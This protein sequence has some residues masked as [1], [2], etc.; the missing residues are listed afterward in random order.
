MGTNS[1]MIKRFK[2]EN[3]NGRV[4]CDL[5]F[6]EDIN[7]VTGKNGSGKTTLLKLLWF[8]ISGNNERILHEM[9]FTSAEVE[10]SDYDLS[11][12][13]EKRKS[14][15]LMRWEIK[16]PDKPTQ[17]GIGH[18]E[19]DRIEALN[20]LVAGVGSSLFFPTFRRIEGGFSMGVSGR[21]FADGEQMVLLDSPVRMES[22]FSALAN[23]LSVRGH[24]FVTS[25]STQDIV[26]SLT[27]HYADVSERINEDHRKLSTDIFDLMKRHDE[28][29]NSATSEAKKLEIAQ[30]T[31]ES[32]QG[33]VKLHAGKQENLLRPFSALS[34]LISRIFQHKGIQVTSRVTLGDAQQ[35]IASD[36]LSAGEKQMLSFLVYNAFEHNGVIFIDEPE[37]SLHVDWQRQLFPTLLQQ[38]TANQFIVA[39]H[40][41][42]IYS[43]YSDRELIL[44]DD[45]GG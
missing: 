7:I 17:T 30:E 29:T 28:L 24:H 19:S 41:P 36:K 43:K 18:P 13:T 2:V 11:I 31:L 38:G 6:H 32:I 5:N 4:S 15:P 44:H 39:T 37:I 33:Q 3:L 1:T 8:M 45:R 25:I 12:R 21:R 34:D 9:D 14:R 27:N 16:M 10:T 35:A 42:F 20:R 26:S 40:S 22:S 23:L